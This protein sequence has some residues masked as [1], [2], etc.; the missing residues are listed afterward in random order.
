MYLDEPQKRLTTD[1]Y[2]SN[3]LFIVIRALNAAMVVDEGRCGIEVT[4]D[5]RERFEIAFKS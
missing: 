3:F 4:C 1:T 5:T 2:G